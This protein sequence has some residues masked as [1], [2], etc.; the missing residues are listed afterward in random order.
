MAVEIERKFLVE[1]APWRGVRG[2]KLRQGYLS[3]AAG[4]T[5]RVRIAGAKAYLTIKGK[6]RGFS[7]AEFEYAVPLKDARALLKLCGGRLIE[8]TRYRILFGGLV[9]EVDRF[10][11]ANRG[12]V[13]AEVEL[14]RE[15]QRVKRPLWARAEVTRDRRYYN[16]SLS[17]RPY[18]AWR[19]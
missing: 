6:T 4:A 10:E 1:G 16:S 19:A 15:S 17:R 12:L 2:V 18:R 9:W 5:V 13:L 11:G 14:R 8:K 7:R 3:D